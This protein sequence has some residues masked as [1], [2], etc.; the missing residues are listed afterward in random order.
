M[1]DDGL[2]DPQKGTVTAK[3]YKGSGRWT[4]TFDD[5]TDP[6]TIASFNKPGVYELRLEVTNGFLLARDTVRFTV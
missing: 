6:T 5:D 1:I 3:W 4:V 2:G